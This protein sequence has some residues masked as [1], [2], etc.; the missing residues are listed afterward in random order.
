MTAIII[1]AHNEAARIDATLQAVLSSIGDEG[2]QVIVVCNGCNDDTA[3]RARQY[4]PRVCV[5]E[6]TVASKTNALNLGDE[7]ASSF[8]RIYLD[9]DVIVSKSLV[10]DLVRALEAGSS[11]RCVSGRRIRPQVL[12]DVGTCFLWRVAVIAV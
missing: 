3:D 12:V 11:A 4:A 2:V 5:L 1:P 8:P 6:T 9:A 7:A 10:S